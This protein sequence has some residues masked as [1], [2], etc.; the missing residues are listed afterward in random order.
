MRLFV[1]NVL[2]RCLRRTSRGEPFLPGHHRLRGIHQRGQLA[3]DRTRR[4]QP[5][6]GIKVIGNFFQTLGVRPQMGCLFTAEEARKGAQPVALLAN[7]YW[8]RQFAAD[9]AIVG[10]TIDLDGRA[11]TAVG[12]LPDSFDFGAVFSPGGFPSS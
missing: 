9:S 2:S 3:A 10:K 5:A 8:R 11:T 12:V 7:A 1:L 4:A 6:T